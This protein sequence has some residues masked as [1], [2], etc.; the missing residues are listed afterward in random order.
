[1]KRFLS[2]PEYESNASSSAFIQ[3]PLG[4]YQTPSPSPVIGKE[5]FHLPERPTSEIKLPLIIP[6]SLRRTRLACYHL[7]VYSYHT[8]PYHTITIVRI[9]SPGGYG[10]DESND[11]DE[12]DDE[13]N[14]GYGDGDDGNG[15]ANDGN[16]DDTGCNARNAW[17]GDV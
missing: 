13:P 5:G 1:M 4:S 14:D 2:T 15:N 6:L 11:D 12:P 7:L 8:P 17:D 3:V 16:G 10:R 9:D